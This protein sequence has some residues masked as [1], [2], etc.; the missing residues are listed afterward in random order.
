M[1]RRGFVGKAAGGVG[2]LAATV[3]LTRTA[4]A[5]ST[6]TVKADVITTS[7]GTNP[8]KET[9]IYN[10]VSVLTYGA[11][12]NG[13][14]DDGPA[15]QNAA[16]A[17]AAAFKKLY[18]PN[19]GSPYLIDTFL[20][21][22]SNG[23]WL[24]EAGAILNISLTCSLGP[25]ELGG[26]NRAM[27]ANNASVVEFEN[28]IFESSSSGLSKLGVSIAFNNTA[29]VRIKNCIF[30]NFGDVTYYAQGLVMFGCSDVIIE[31][32]TFSGNSGDGVAFAST[33]TTL[34]FTNNTCI[35]NGDCGVVITVAC[36]NVIIANNICT[37]SINCGILSDRCQN[38]TIC[39]NVCTNNSY[40][41]RISRYVATSDA[42]QFVSV[43]GNTVNNSGTAGISVELC[44]SPSSVVVTGN[45]VG[46]SGGAGIN[47]SDACVGTIAGN[48]VCSTAGP[49]IAVVSYNAG[50]ETGRLA[51]TGNILTNGTYGIQQITGPGTIT[52][53]VISGNGIFYMS[54][55]PTSLLPGASTGYL[56]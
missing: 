41:I 1:D 3:A 18:F 17:A 27:F 7:A 11:I 22:P 25:T 23:Y 15:I 45:S 37:D 56:S 44:T 55:A 35:Q 31:G 40:G 8:I 4:S 53:L 50:Y 30:R 20:E 34:K 38:V 42:N 5:Q 26:S 9:D 49:S 2:L 14:T 32:C 12:G 13:T 52:P 43:T 36:S 33:C 46:G 54:E 10:V 28:L 51:I 48:T 29:S 16:N 6:T 39:G 47:W 24:G 21:V 19:T